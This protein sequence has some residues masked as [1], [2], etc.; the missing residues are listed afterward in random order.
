M[1]LYH[2]TSRAYLPSILQHGINRGDIATT[3]THGFN[4]PALTANPSWEESDQTWSRRTGTPRA[5]LDKLAVRLTVKVPEDCTFVEP[6]L[7]VIKRYDPDPSWRAHHGDIHEEAPW[8]LSLKTIPKEWVQTWELN[9]QSEGGFDFNGVEVMGRLKTKGAPHRPQIGVLRKAEWTRVGVHKFWRDM[10]HWP[11]LS[12]DLRYPWSDMPPQLLRTLAGVD[13]E[14]AVPCGLLWAATRGLTP[15]WHSE[16]TDYAGATFS[17]L[18]RWLQG[19]RRIVDISDQAART[20]LEAPPRFDSLPLAHAAPWKSGCLFR[21]RIGKAEDETHALVYAEPFQEYGSPGI[22]YGVWSSEVGRRGWTST[23]E[24]HQADDEDWSALAARLKAVGIPADLD[25]M[26]AWLYRLLAENSTRC[27]PTLTRVDELLSRD[28]H[29]R[30]VN[31]KALRQLQHLA[32]NALAA[33]HAEPHALVS[34]RKAKTRRRKEGGIARVRK[35]R[36]SEDGARLVTRKW[37]EE[38]ESNLPPGEKRAHKPQCLH[39]MEEHYWRVWV[40]APREAEQVLETRTRLHRDGSAFFQYRVLRLRGVGGYTRGG[41]LEEREARM[42]RG[43][44]DL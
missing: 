7:D 1:V 38:G 28:E 27:L 11:T 29:G 8:Y 25:A 13:P 23:A 16:T 18:G 22:R 33:I 14:D 24:R 41:T 31:D 32:I 4:A 20:L 5:Q 21:V 43:L 26:P 42:V 6:Y 44:G 36:L 40:N 19:S 9:P 15:V 17:I 37:I 12:R 3:A 2:F 35:L 39:K 10:G 30:S 34:H